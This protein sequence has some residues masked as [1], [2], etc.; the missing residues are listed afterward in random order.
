MAPG[1]Q[2]SG[3][4]NSIAIRR[5]YRETQAATIQAWS[6]LSNSPLVGCGLQR[7]R[8][9]VFAWDDAHGVYLLDLAGRVLAQRRS[10]K[11]LLRVVSA[12]T[13]ERLAAVGRHGQIWW[14][15]D[16]LRP[17]TEVLTGLKPRA[18]ALD[19]FGEY[20]AVAGEGSRL[21]VASWTGQI[22]ADVVVGQTMDHLSFVPATGRI[23]GA[24]EQGYLA[25]HDVHGNLVWKE[26]MFSTVGG[27]AVDGS[28]EAILLA[29]YGHG[30]I[31]FTDN[32]RREGTYQIERSPHAVAIDM[33]AS[34]LLAATIDSHAVALNLDGQVLADRSLG[35]RAVS[36]AID[37]LGRFVVIGFGSGEVRLC[38]WDEI[39]FAPTEPRQRIDPQGGNRPACDASPNPMPGAAWATLAVKD[40]QE[41]SSAVLTPVP[42]SG[43]LA[44]FSSSRTLRIF[45]GKG[46]LKHES[47]PIEGAGR[48]LWAA[49][50]WLAAATDRRLLG[51]DPASN[52]SL[53]ASTSVYELS[54][55]ALFPGF[56]ECLFVESCDQ[57]SRLRLPGEVMWKERLPVRVAHIAVDPVGRVA[58]VFEDHQLVVL[59]PDG[60]LIGRYRPARPESMLVSPRRGGWMTAARGEP[61]VRGHDELGELVWTTPLPWDPWSLKRLGFFAVVTSA[62]G[63]SLLVAD[64]GAILEQNNESRE[65]AMY[66]LA[67]DGK[68]ARLYRTGQTLIATSFDGRLRWRRVLEGPIGSVTV[69]LMGVWALMDRCLV[70]FPFDANPRRR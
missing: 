28:G 3:K 69:N 52:R 47:P 11:P 43:V 62:D 58:L 29:C 38:P 34:R 63:R 1:R 35:D 59:D 53:M 15:D 32:G 7:E 66:F 26:T 37:A 33:D 25:L 17:V 67:A 9:R 42:E 18:A 57:I 24:A 16:E 6:W 8:L 13:G 61:V 20:I 55:V 49:D 31:R 19:P 23:V 44:M 12:D 27:L 10:P 40:W 60:R 2:D 48:T 70:H 14:L 68:P 64:D 4:G 45:D 56:G 54:H 50:S 5:R 65:G 46:D 21:F 41:A 36:V 30:L 51:Y 39:V 22:L